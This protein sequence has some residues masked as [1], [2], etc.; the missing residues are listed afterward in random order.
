[1]DDASKKL[2]EIL[3]SSEGLDSIMSVVK[4]L[5][6]SMPALGTQQES[7]STVS[8]QNTLPAPPRNDFDLS[9]LSKLDPR[10]TSAAM[11]VLRE[12]SS[13]DEKITLLYALNPHLADT[14]QERI[15]KAAQILRISRSIR[16]LI[17]NLGGTANV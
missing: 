13:Y 7:T 8:E 4:S 16:A 9:A 5:T 1:M 6:G 10:F 3:S 15:D 2:S 11:N 17:N 14:R 12:F